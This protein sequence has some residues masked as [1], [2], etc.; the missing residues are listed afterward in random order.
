MPSVYPGALDSLPINHFDDPSQIIYAAHVNDLADAVNKIEAELDANPS[1]AFATVKARL[2]AIVGGGGFPIINVKDAAY[3][4]VGNG[5]TDDRVAIQAALDAVPAAGGCVF[6]PPGIYLVNSG[7]GFTIK[8][9]TKILGTSTPRYYYGEPD[10]NCYIKLGGSFAGT[11]LWAPGGSIRGVSW[12]SIGIYG[13]NLGTPGPTGIHCFRLPESAAITGE[14]SFNFHKLHISG[15][16]GSGICGRLHVG[17]FVD[18]H[19]SNCG[20]W[21]IETETGTNNRWSDVK[22]I[23]GYLY[24]GRYGGLHLGGVNSS[25][26]GGCQFIGTRFER[27]GNTGGSPLSPLRTDS[28]GVKLTNAIR[29]S[30]VG[31]DTDGNTGDGFLFTREGTWGSCYGNQIIG[32]TVGRDGGGDQATLPDRASIRFKGFSG[33]AHVDHCKVIGGSAIAGRADDGGGG[34]ISPKYGVIL[35]YA[36]DCSFEGYNAEG[37]TARWNIGGGGAGQIWRTQIIDPTGHILTIPALD[38]SPSQLLFDGSG[39]QMQAWIDTTGA[40]TLFKVRDGGA[41][42]SVALT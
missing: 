38:G 29:I 24:Y 7:T 5:S 8:S 9:K 42:K 36:Y 30:F 2:D 37:A 20:H 1:G 34:I 3:G 12:D 26:S 40:T 15:F 41:T 39:Q 14:Q 28:P 10:S 17:T 13:S 4:A 33:A 16:T 32:A 11:S 31:C 27:S 18:C 19:I 21:C 35:D 6:F 22:F 25:Q 23:G